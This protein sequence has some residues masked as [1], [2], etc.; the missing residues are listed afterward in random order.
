VPFAPFHATTA[1]PR[2]VTRGFSRISQMLSSVA[3][4]GGDETPGSDRP[5]VLQRG[6]R[7]HSLSRITQSEVASGFLRMGPERNPFGRPSRRSPAPLDRSVVR[8]IPRDRTD[9]VLYGRVGSTGR[10]VS[11][12]GRW[13]DFC[14][15]MFRQ[16]AFVPSMLFVE[17]SPA[18][19]VYGLSCDRADEIVGDWPVA[20]QP[21][22]RR[23]RVRNLARL[24]PR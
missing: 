12:Q 13:G 14:G 7:T 5:R 2:P 1:E 17:V 18:R 21:P 9:P 11:A 8:T 24:H 16:E 20:L 22:M 15:G 19:A 10:A 3:I 4:L 6:K 23:R